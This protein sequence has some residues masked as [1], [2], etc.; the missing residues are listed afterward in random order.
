[1]MIP[2][3]PR[4][5]KASSL[6]RRSAPERLEPCK[7][8]ESWRW[9]SSGTRKKQRQIWRNTK[10]RSRRRRRSSAIRWAVLWPIRAIRRR[11][12]ISC[13][14]AFQ[15]SNFCWQSSTLTGT[16]LFAL[17]ARD[18]PHA[19]N[20]GTMKKSP[21]KREQSDRADADE[22]LPEYDFSRAPRKVRIT[23]CCGKC[24]SGAG[25]RCGRG[26]P[27]FRRGQ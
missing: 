27:K 23:V 4:S 9:S 19:V 1:M 24:G 10:S 17:S 5:T 15:T 12:S 21:S 7:Y 22:I 11:R 14:W 2:E 25:A 3:S 18:G 13:C 26:L 20:E 6:G 8:N 16:K